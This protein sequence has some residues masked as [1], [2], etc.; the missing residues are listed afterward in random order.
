MAEHDEPLDVAGQDGGLV[1]PDQ[2]G[3]L[4]DGVL[5]DVLE[6]A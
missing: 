4:L 5:E 2:G 1:Q 6:Q 3:A